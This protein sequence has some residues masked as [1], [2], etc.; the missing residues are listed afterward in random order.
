VTAVTGR[1]EW[2]PDITFAIINLKAASFTI[3]ENENQK[4]LHAFKTADG[5]VPA[6]IG[7]FFKNPPR[8]NWHAAHGSSSSAETVSD[9]LSSILAGCRCSEISG[10]AYCRDGRAFICRSPIECRFKT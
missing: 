6:T 10:A 7:V 4:I 1:W 8:L 2:V 5:C 3:F 9:A